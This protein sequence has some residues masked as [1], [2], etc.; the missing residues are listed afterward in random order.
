VGDHERIVIV[1]NMLIRDHPTG[2]GEFMMEGIIPRVCIAA[3]RV[4]FSRG[5]AFSEP[6]AKALFVDFDKNGTDAIAN[7]ALALYFYEVWSTP[8]TIAFPLP[9]AM[10]FILFLSETSFV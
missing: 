3:G 6:S 7:L 1:L 4:D 9:T 5:G 2:I 10:R 8:I